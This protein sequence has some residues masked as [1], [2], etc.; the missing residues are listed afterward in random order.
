MS[1]WNPKARQENS[2]ASAIGYFERN[3]KVNYD[4]R[5]S[6]D[7][8]GAFKM[9]TINHHIKSLGHSPDPVGLFFSILDQFTNTASFVSEGK[10]IKVD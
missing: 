3:F 8:D 9:G 6:V 1:G 4:H 5:S 2:I 7:V 10:L